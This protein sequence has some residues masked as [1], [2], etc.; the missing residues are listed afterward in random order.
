MRGLEQGFADEVLRER[1]VAIGP[2]V[3]QA[4]AIGNALERRTVEAVSFAGVLE[5]LQSPIVLLDPNAR[6]LHAN[7][8]AR[9]VLR[10]RDPL[11]DVGGHLFLTPA[12]ARVWLE[13]GLADSRLG[14]TAVEPGD[15]TIVLGRHGTGTLIGHSSHSRLD[16]ECSSD[17]SPG[18][19]QR[20]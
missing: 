13:P 5:R 10:A 11:C 7:D 12:P 3:R 6:I 17:G 19:P 15:G 8:S 14:E 2:H 4:V 9:E 18:P 20:S 1:L 16:S